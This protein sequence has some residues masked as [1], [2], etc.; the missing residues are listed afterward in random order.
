Y[1]RG[2]RG[3]CGDDVP[4]ALHDEK[5]ILKRLAFLFGMPIMQSSAAHHAALEIEVSKPEVIKIDD[6]EYVRR[7]TAAEGEIKIAV[8]DRGFVYVGQVDRA[9]PEMLVLRHAKNIRVWGTTK[10]LGELVNGPTSSTKLDHVGTVR[11]P[12]RALISLIDVDQNKWT[13]I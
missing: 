13:L 5:I 3:N 1:W 6:V 7:D 8:L 11:V 4:F 10:G 12:Y 2:A 9:D